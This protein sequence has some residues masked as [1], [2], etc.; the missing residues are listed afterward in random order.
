MSGSFDDMLSKA[1]A[2]LADQT[3]K[4]GIAGKQLAQVI[5]TT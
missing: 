1:K 2:Y 4:H 5:C 3:A